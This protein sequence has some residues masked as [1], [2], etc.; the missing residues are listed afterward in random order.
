MLAGSAFVGTAIRDITA[1]SVVV[2]EVV[3][4]EPVVMTEVLK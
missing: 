3:G 2:I 4:I 1:G